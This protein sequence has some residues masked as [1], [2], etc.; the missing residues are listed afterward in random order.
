MIRLLPVLLLFA[1]PLF[2]ETLIATR[3]IPA[4]TIIG[5]DDLALRDVNIVGGI[6]DPSMAIGKEARVA[7]YAGRP[8][9]AGDLSAPAIIERNQIIPLVYQRGGISI[10]TEGRALERG[11]A[12]DWIRVMNLSSRSSVTAEIQET[13][14]AH[15]Y[16]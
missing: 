9:R 11:G 3:T 2:A 1:S 16:N 6:S 7:L 5:P 4:R 15:V 13:G 8:I 10:S 12:G 14:V